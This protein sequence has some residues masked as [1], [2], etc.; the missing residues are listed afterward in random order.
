M[1][2]KKKKQATKKHNYTHKKEGKVKIINRK[3][4]IEDQKRLQL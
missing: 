2:T 3:R 4:H 1:K